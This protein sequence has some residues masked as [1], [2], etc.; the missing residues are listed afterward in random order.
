MLAT[1]CK[2]SVGYRDRLQKSFGVFAGRTA[3]EGLAG[4]TVLAYG[5]SGERRAGRS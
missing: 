4:L 3:A 5:R 2:R 1:S